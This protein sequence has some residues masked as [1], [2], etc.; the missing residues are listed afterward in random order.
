MT[1][2]TPANTI[3]SA[4]LRLRELSAAEA[5][6]VVGGRAPA[7]QSWAPGYPLDGTLAAG[8]A[9]LRAAA[10]GLHRPGFGMYQIIER[11]SGQVVGDIGFHGAPDTDGAAEIGYGI[12]PAFRG[13]GLVSESLRSLAQ[14]A[15]TQP[16]VRE[17]QA[18][19]EPDHTPSQRVLT[20]A[21]FTYTG[22]QDGEHRYLRTRPATSA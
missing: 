9:F 19:T 6:E 7:G 2:P 5:A 15:F 14:W 1:D 20:R 12:V 13:R 18:G 3:E 21:G 16:D 4:R 11:E 10:A 17:L 22:V 8:G